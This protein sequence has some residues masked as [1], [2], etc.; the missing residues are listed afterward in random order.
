MIARLVGWVLSAGLQVLTGAHGRWSGCAPEARQRVYCVNH[1]SHLDF[2]LLWTALP[3]AM[4]RVT[5]PVAAA[6]YWNSGL[7]RRY[8]IHDVFRGVLVDRGGKSAQPLEPAVAALAAG[9]SLIFFPEGTRGPG[10][11]LLPFKSG[12][13]Y[14][15][16]ERPDV[17]LVPV[18]IDNSYR[19]M[20]KG[21]FFPVPLVCSMTFGA[22]LRLR[23]GEEKEA[24][25]SRLRNAMLELQP[26]Q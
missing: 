11:G 18:W 7:V 15:A 17:D 12:I 13:Y 2:L 1:S 4:R 23:E 19:V 5:R 6:D 21:R 22:P 14:L 26:P 20:P 24:F 3:A 25:L 8:V 16:K 10:A 9:D